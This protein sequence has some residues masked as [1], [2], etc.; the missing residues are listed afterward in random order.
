MHASERA[1]ASA[2]RRAG[3]SCMW[4]VIA[5]TMLVASP[6]AAQSRTAAIGVSVTVRG[7]DEA[8][9]IGA[10]A[11]ALRAPE[12]VVDGVPGATAESGSWRLSAGGA[13][14]MSVRLEAVDDMLVAGPPPYLAICEAVDGASTQCHREQAA[15]MRVLG[16]SAHAEYLVRAGRYSVGRDP[17]L[18][19]GR[20]RLTIA[21]TTT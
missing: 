15:T 8:D 1:R 19:A 17:E 13:L 6:V 2:H 3:S 11:M 18:R 7:A 20:V 9:V 14:E 10:G 5:V 21:F 12:S 16:G 4:C